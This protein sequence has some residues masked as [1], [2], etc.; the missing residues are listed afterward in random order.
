MDKIATKEALSAVARALDSKIDY[1]NDKMDYIKVEISDLDVF[2]ITAED[3]AAI[4]EHID[5]WPKIILTSGNMG[6]R[7]L[8]YDKPNNIIFYYDL[9][10]GQIAMLSLT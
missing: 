8:S 7:I 10:N 9:L 5:S 1:L 4:L 3:K 6:S 2:E